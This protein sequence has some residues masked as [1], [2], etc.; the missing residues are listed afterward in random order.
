[1][2]V[3]KPFSAALAA[4]A[5]FTLA[6]ALSACAAEAPEQIALGAEAPVVED[7]PTAD[8]KTV[9]LADFKDAKAVVVVFTCNHCPVA[10]AYEGRFNAFA[11]DY[12]G[13]PVKFLA[14]SV[15][16]DKADT[17]EAT[18]KYAKEQGL[19][20]TYAHD[21]SQRTGKAFGANRTPHAFVLGPDRTVVYRGAF[22][23]SWRS[24]EKVK[25]TYVRDAVDAILAG[26]PVAVPEAKSVGCGIDYAD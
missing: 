25:K 26:E 3:S 6:P 24:A 18:K 1:M 23:D 2:R 20:F 10:K 12:E 11:A 7:L 14:I 19:K 21:A 8:G 4:A 16:N 5:A 17:L 9:S 13:K 22:D 15:S